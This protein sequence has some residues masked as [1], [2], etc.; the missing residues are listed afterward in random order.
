M[1]KLPFP[2]VYRISGFSLKP[3]MF[4][5]EQCLSLNHFLKWYNFDSVNIWLEIN[6][7][8]I[9]TWHK[10]I[11]DVNNKIYKMIPPLVWIVPFV[12]PF[13]LSP[14]LIQLACDINQVF[15]IIWIYLNPKN[16]QLLLSHS[17]FTNGWLW[18]MKNTFSF[19]HVSKLA[20]GFAPFISTNQLWV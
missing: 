13:A 19:N 8:N 1:R 6:V 7:H 15:E 4:L 10:N 17:S 14:Q 16:Q 3:L 11:W 5:L 2:F 18:Q 12:P 9:C 20:P